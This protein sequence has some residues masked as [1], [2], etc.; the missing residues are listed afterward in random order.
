[1]PDSSWKRLSARTVSDH[2]ILRLREDLYRFEPAD[3]EREFVVI[4]APDWVN[5]VALTDELDVV[6]IRQFRHGVGCVTLEIPGGVVDEGE[7]PAE[8][9]LR[10]L[11]E[12][13]GYSAGRAEGVGVVWPNPAIQDNSCHVFL[14]RGARRVGVPRPDPL[15]RIEVV[16]TPL[17]RIPA[18]IRE[19]KIRHALVIAAFGM[20]DML[21]PARGAQR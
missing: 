10:E 1:V 5:V 11:R 16:T 2:R 18:L 15:E 9:A 19:G 12:E 7:E 20:I 6:L 3:V 14:A 13:T 21:G 8:C 4:E 17:A